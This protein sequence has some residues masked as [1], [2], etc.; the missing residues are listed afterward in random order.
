MAESQKQEFKFPTEVVDLPSKGKL[1]PEGSPLRSGQ[2]EI[3]YMTAKEEDILTS[4][5]L[6]KK[7]VVIDK[8]LDSLIISPD[9][10]VGDLLVGDKNAVM[11]ASRILAYGAEY[12]CEITNPTNM[13][14]KLE[15]TFDLTEVNFKQLPDNIDYQSNSFELELP[16]SKNTITFKMLTG[17]DESSITQ[18]LKA[19]DKIGQN[20]EVTTRLKHL[21]TSVNGNSDKSTIN[22][23]CENML[24]KESLFLRDEVA[25][26]NPDVDLKQTIEIGGESTEVDIPMTVAFF[27]PK[28]GI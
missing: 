15:H 10:K 2:I 18:E 23:F 1:Y 20:A 8:L 14:E 28:S 26:I 25:R 4:Q 27:W 21:I 16:I 13:A 17:K 12:K 6:I 9:I 3:K 11:I 5:N 7:G 24:S 19:L 22:S